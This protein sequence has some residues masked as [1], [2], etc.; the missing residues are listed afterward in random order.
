MRYEG[1]RTKHARRHTHGRSSTPHARHPGNVQGTAT[2]SDDE[3]GDDDD[4]GGEEEEEDD[5]G[6]ND[7]DEEEEED[8]KEEE[9]CVFTGTV[10]AFKGPSTDTNLFLK[11]MNLARAA[12]AQNT[13]ARK[14]PTLPSRDKKGRGA[15]THKSGGR[16]NDPTLATLRR[17]PGQYPNEHFTVACRQLWCQACHTNV[18]GDVTSIEA[19][20]RAKKH[21]DAKKLMAK[22]VTKA[23]EVKQALAE[24]KGMSRRPQA[25]AL[26]T[27]I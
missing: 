21:D 9:E 5:D 12:P 6:D 22:N 23:C 25:S 4:D 24:Y 2:T 8:D 3:E 20:I 15:S 13:K 19:H 1:H 10:K 11:K 14:V 27:P 17:R 18:G 26:N 16:K 7:D